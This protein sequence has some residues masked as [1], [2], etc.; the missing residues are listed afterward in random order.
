[1]AEPRALVTGAAGFVGAHLVRRLLAEGW[2]VTAM[3]RPGSDTGRLASE[4]ERLALV[5]ADVT[6]LEPDTVAARAEVVFHLAAVGLHE[7]RP[8]PPEEVMRTNVVGTLNVLRLAAAL[9]ARRVVH[10]G[11]GHE[12]G[13]GSR[14]R[15]DAPLRPGSAY[16]ASKAAA[17]HLASAFCR[18]RGLELVVLRPF[19]LYGPGDS[20]YSFVASAIAACLGNEPLE[21]TE[22]RQSRD[23]VFA[24]DAVD[25]LVASAD[26]SANGETLNVCT[27]V[28]I[29]IREVVE[30]IVALTGGAGRPLFGA[31]P[32][33]DDELWTSSGS[34]TR[35]RDVLGW[36]ATTDLR[37]GLAAT[38]AS[39]RDA[40]MPREPETV[41]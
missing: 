31:R 25:A 22:G 24:A 9:G 29:S 39:Y 21:L 14:L 1:M 33:S 11:S 10:V 36:E 27:G 34:P 40:G 5:E 3:V 17:W 37:E 16:G 35:A 23:F 30:L 6:T 26:A 19:T 4:L 41:R 8:R 18:L 7:P 15:E 38:V 13:A 12:Y 2:D 32:Y 28:E 20:P